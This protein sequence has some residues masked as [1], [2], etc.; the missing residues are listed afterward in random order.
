MTLRDMILAEHSLAQTKK[1]I[2]W[3]GNSQKRFDELFQL[4]NGNEYRI[5]QRAS[6]P[7]SH[8]GLSHPNLVKKHFSKLVK[9][10]YKASAH[11]AVKRNTVRILQGIHIPK[12]YHGEIMDK[13]FTYITDPNEAIAV[14]AFSLKILENM[15]SLYPDI[16]NELKVII[17]ER[18]N[19]ETAAFRSRAK[20]ILK[21][22]QPGN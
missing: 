20:K 17:E 1:I 19:H 5:T 21:K 6:W 16:G 4:F 15:L 2:K 10:L 13:C 12:R 9:N 22:L 8:I 3:V 18:W 11:E 14:K 7:L